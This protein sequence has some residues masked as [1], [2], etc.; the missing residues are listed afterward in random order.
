MRVSCKRFRNVL[1]VDAQRQ[2]LG[3]GGLAHPRVAHVDGVVLAP[4]AQHV[5]GAGDLVVAA[6]ERVQQALGGLLH[7]LGGEGFQRIALRRLPAFL[8]LLRPGSVRLRLLLRQLGDAVGDV[9]DEVEAADVL[10]FQQVA[11]VALL[12]TVHGHQQVAALDLGLLRGLGVN[13][14]AL[15]DTVKAQ[16]LLR[17]LLRP[18]GQRL[19]AAL[20]ELFQLVPQAVEVA[21]AVEDDF[22]GVAVVEQHHTTGARRRR[23]RAAVPLP[24]RNA[25]LSTASRFLVITPLPLRNSLRFE[26]HY[27][28]KLIPLR[29]ST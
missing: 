17:L 27:P 29:W 16:G 2:P 4:P 8:V 7:Q 19:Q 18:L 22:A 24:R 9:V 25:A 10:G 3:D 5:D 1:L 11:G 13:E 14:G 21:A 20:E 23:T 6:D 26:A 15:D 28:S 12:L